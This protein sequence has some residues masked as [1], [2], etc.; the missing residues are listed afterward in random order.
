ML[1]KLA[2]ALLAF[3][4][5]VSCAVCQAESPDEVPGTVDLPYA[6][7]RFTPP[8]EYRNTRG[9]IVNEGASELIPGITCAYWVYCA[10]TAEEV[11]AILSGSPDAGPAVAEPLF[12]VFV[13]SDGNT[14]D[15]LNSLAGGQFSPDCVHD[16]GTVGE[17]SF[18]LY[19][20]GPYE[21]FTAYIDEEYAKEYTELAGMTEQVAAAFTCY[22][23]LD[24][25][26]GIIGKKVSF[27]TTDMDGNAVSSDELFARSDVT[28]VNIWASWCG[29]CARELPELEQIHLR[30]QEKGCGVIGLLGDRDLDAARSLMNDSGVTYPVILAPDNF[31][32]LFRIEAWPTT[33]FV[34]RDGTI[35]AAP[36][37]GAYVDRYEAALSDLLGPQE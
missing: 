26:A 10:M 34:G 12:Y 15:T 22:E 21:P 18:C 4:L 28:M 23:P 2:A 29:P 8:E 27:T 7:I 32:D 9:Q 16:L 35:L 37:T 19:M 20:E 24:R 1:K 13:M 31:E 11:E 30:L 36:I 5:L 17:Y 6:G 14:F 25:Y 3:A 33:Y